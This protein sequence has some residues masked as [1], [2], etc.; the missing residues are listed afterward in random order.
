VIQIEWNQVSASKMAA[1]TEYPPPLS[2]SEEGYGKGNVTAL[3]DDK[4]VE[5]TEVVNMGKPPRD[6]PPICRPVSSAQLASTT[7]LV[8]TSVFTDT[9]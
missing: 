8:R 6:L 9:S 5:S 3:T 4:T 7:E 1:G 2:N